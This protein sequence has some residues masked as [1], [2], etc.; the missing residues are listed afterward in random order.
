MKVNMSNPMKWPECHWSVQE[1]CYLIRFHPSP[2]HH[3][4]C[5]NY[6]HSR[7][8][9]EWCHCHRILFD[10][11]KSVGLFCREYFPGYSGLVHPMETYKATKG[12]KGAKL[13]VFKSRGEQTYEPCV[14]D[15]TCNG[16]WFAPKCFS[17]LRTDKYQHIGNKACRHPWI[18]EQLN[19][20]GQY[21]MFGS[22]VY[23]HGYWNNLRCA[24]TVTSQL[25]CMSST[26]QELNNHNE[27]RQCK[28]PHHWQ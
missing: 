14:G 21:V 13:K 18:E 6:A 24:V 12:M 20:M 8:I 15:M 9:L 2:C 28:G 10:D 1:Q 19:L 26:R 22:N 5:Y 17:C 7:C 16:L 11:P 4:G 3:P 23:H 25:F 27:K